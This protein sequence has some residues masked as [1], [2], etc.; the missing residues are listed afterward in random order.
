MEAIVCKLVSYMAVGV[1]RL[2]CVGVGVQSVRRV[3][4]RVEW[5][6]VILRNAFEPS[7]SR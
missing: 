4:A 1:V 2:V 7:K 5:L 3:S 6:K